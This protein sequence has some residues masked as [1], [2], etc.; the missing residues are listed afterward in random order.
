MR[1]SVLIVCALKIAILGECTNLG[2]KP[3]IVF[4]VAD[5]LGWNDFAI[6]G[7]N[8]IPT[9]NIDAL[10]YNGAILHN[11]YTQQSCT[12][13]RAALLT[14]NYPIRTGLQGIPL[15]SGENRSLPIDMPTMGER[16]QELGYKTHMVGKWHL[17]AACKE[18][19]P[20]KRGFDTHFGYWNGYVGYFDYKISTPINDTHNFTGFDLHNEFKPEWGLIGQYATELFTKKSLEVIDKHD[21]D[22]P[23]FLMINHLAGHAGHDGVELG[24]PNVTEANKK[25]GYIKTPERRLLADIVNHLDRSVGEVITKMSEK[26]MLDNSII[27][28]FSDNGAQTTGKYQNFA[29]GW[30]F[31]GLKFT[32]LEGGVRGTGIIYSPLLEKRRYVN[33]HLIHITDWLPTLYHIAGGDTKAL[34]KIDGK[35]QW[36]TISRN[37]T[38][39]RTDILLNIDE[40]NGYSGMLGYGGQYKLLN[41][42]Y[43]DGIYN[44]YYGD[45]GREPENPDYNIQGILNSPTNIAIQTI[46]QQPLTPAQIKKLRAEVD[47]KKYKPQGTYPTFTCDEYCL[48]DLHADPCE[49]TN[50][51]GDE[52]KQ[53]IVK[54]LKKKLLAYNQQ[55]VPQTNKPVDVNSNPALFNNTWFPWLKCK[56]HNNIWLGSVHDIKIYS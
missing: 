30:P 39:K 2:S 34:G 7:S 22:K 32:L 47:M 36:N 35:N 42:S 51:I 11:F 4:M 37:D 19:T 40:V 53:D 55:L 6:H 1:K 25:Y 56:L 15:D 12:P 33:R 44:G 41:G 49:T 14:G 38:T 27:I 31:R 45:H 17:G 16:F 26:K 9:P 24:V 23:L 10:A 48:F 50:L 18:V 5:D 3:H 46:E 8:Q 20:T 28:F 43:N 13:S 54:N 52:E 29:S 21:T